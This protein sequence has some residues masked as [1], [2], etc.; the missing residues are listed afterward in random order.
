MPSVSPL[1]LAL[2]LLPCFLLVSPGLRA[3]ETP[4]EPVA[5]VDLAR[6]MGTW[7]EIA[8]YPNRFEEDC[9]ADVTA[10]YTSREDG[11]IK[12]VN[13]CRTTDG[14]FSEAVGEARRAG[15]GNDPRLEVRFA[16][17][18]IGFLPFVWGDYWIVDLDEGYT[19]AAVGD[20]ARKY[21]WILSRSPV[22]SPA[23]LQALMSRLKNKGFDPARLISS[24]R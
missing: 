18:W 21:L 16:P 20:P 8:R 14:T 13:R 4:L 15:S 2:L 17:K 7:H 23:R 5:W 22:V 3:G 9:V 12:V 6:Y 19:L 24:T 11:R 1:R 10:T